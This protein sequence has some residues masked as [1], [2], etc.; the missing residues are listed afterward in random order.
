[1]IQLGGIS[2]EGEFSSKYDIYPDALQKHVYFGDGLL[3]PGPKIFLW[4]IITKSK[5]ASTLK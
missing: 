4:E 5:N 2:L 1:M 3:I